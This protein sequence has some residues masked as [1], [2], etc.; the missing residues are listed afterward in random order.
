MPNNLPEFVYAG[1]SKAA[2]T[3]MHECLR[4]HPELTLPDTDSLNFFDIKYHCG[5]DWY[6]RQFAHADKNTVVGEMTPSYLRS[7][8]AAARIS[9]TLEDPTVFFCLRNPVDRAFSHW[10]HS[11][12]KEYVT[13]D[14]EEIFQINPAFQHWIVPGFY[15]YHLDRYDE[16]FDDANLEI[17]FFDDLIEDDEAFIQDIYGTLGVDNEYVPEPIGEKTN[18][19]GYNVPNVLEYAHRTGA[20]FFPQPLKDAVKP[21]YDRF[22]EALG[23]RSAYDEGMDAEIREQIERLYLHD[24][25][26]LSERTGRDLDHWFE[27]HS[28]KDTSSDVTPGYGAIDSRQI[29]H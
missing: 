13:Y 28:L 15:A 6:E 11:R 24:V 23:D 22:Q 10:W 8:G 16:Y 14:F 9:K 7:E 25:R 17:L 4:D 29:E 19:A 21:I 1:T 12:R 2:S 20:R 18:A 26:R 3:W 5:V 27:F